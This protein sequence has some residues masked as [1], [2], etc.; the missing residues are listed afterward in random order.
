MDYVDF[1][2]WRV[3]IAF[4]VAVIVGFLDGM[5]ISRSTPAQAPRASQPPA[6]D[7]TPIEIPEAETGRSA[8]LAELWP[9]R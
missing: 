2:I 9:L 1:L 6:I 7:V 4:C 5:I 3:A 8:R